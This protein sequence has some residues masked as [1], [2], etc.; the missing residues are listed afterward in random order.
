MKIIQC[1]HS[2]LDLLVELVEDY[3]VF[4][5]FARSLEASKAFLQKLISSQESVIFIAI[6]TE[7]DK[8][9]G[10]VNLYPSYSTL[11]LQRIWILND[12]G[13]SSVFRGKGVAKALIE[14][15]Q[16]FAKESG[17]IR[18][19]LKTGSENITAQGLYKSLNFIIDND[20]VYYRVPC[21]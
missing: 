4:C 9:M 2:Y 10:F 13:V 20:N 15:V 1:T 17:A 8:L 3:R 7:T 12:L 19:E 18:I 6:D 5:G 21:E 14:K 11:A 16:A